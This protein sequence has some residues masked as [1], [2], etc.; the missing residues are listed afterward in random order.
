MELDPVVLL[1]YASVATNIITLIA[2]V[3]AYA[4]FRMRRRRRRTPEASEEG[5]SASFEPVFLRPYRPM[6]TAA[7]QGA[8][9]VTLAVQG[10]RD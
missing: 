10:G 7:G 6:K 1:A 5:L 3:V 8:G 2:A 4:V 9:E